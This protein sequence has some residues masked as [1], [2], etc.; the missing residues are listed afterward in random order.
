MPNDG[1]S[2]YPPEFVENCFAS[3]E[4][5]L[6]GFAGPNGDEAN[7]STWSP[8]TAGAAQKA[9]GAAATGARGDVPVVIAGTR[10]P[11]PRAVIGGLREQMVAAAVM[12]IADQLPADAAVFRNRLR[13]VALDLLSAGAEKTVRHTRKSRKSR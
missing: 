13:S 2:D 11:R 7:G 9:V 10:S 1:Y 8:M 3:F 5:E 4:G 12:R 6:N